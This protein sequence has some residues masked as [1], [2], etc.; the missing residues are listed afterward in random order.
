MLQNAP[1]EHSAILSTC[2]KLPPVFKTFVLYTLGG[3]LR[4]VSLYNYSS[5]CD[6]SLSAEHLANTTDTRPDN[7]MLVLITYASNEGSE[8]P[9]QVKVQSCKSLRCWYTH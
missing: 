1:V 3:C 2:T 5:T 7:E 8:M 6:S 4:Q 9:E